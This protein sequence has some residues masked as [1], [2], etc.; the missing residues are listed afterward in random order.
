MGFWSGLA[1]GA[2]NMAR[3]AGDHVFKPIGRS[4]VNSIANPTTAINNAAKT[5][6]AKQPCLRLVVISP[7]RT[8]PTTR[9]HWRV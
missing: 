8:L 1:K 6:K 4:A 2:M 5:A 9:A 7:G 3:G